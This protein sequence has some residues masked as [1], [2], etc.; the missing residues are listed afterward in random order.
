[1]LTIDK[2]KEI[3][4]NSIFARGVVYEPKLYKEDEIKWVA[5]RGGIH[6]WAIYYHHADMS[7]EYVK[8]YGDK[9]FSKDV[10]KSLV[11]CDKMAFSMY[12]Y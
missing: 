3:K 8:Y 2:L 6:D 9:V 7:D 4:P 12:R 1:M 10:I 11:P 5:V